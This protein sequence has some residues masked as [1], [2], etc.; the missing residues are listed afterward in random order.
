MLMFTFKFTPVEVFG[1][2]YVTDSSC[3]W[4][5]PL[6]PVDNLHNQPYKEYVQAQA[7]MWSISTLWRIS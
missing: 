7:L 1:G 6:L 3:A 2:L 4:P 5:R